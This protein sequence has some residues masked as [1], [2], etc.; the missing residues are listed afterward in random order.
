MDLE[1]LTLTA[2]PYR[3]LKLFIFATLQSLSFV[4]RKGGWFILFS[5]LAVSLGTR[6][7]AVNGAQGKVLDIPFSICFAKSISNPCDIIYLMI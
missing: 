1:N 5:V 6:L 2:Q 3:T 4:L 7:I